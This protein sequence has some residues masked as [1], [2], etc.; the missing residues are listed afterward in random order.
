[1]GH[2]AEAALITML[3][4]AA[5]QETAAGTDDPGQL[6]SEMNRRL[7]RILPERVYVAA[8]AARVP[9][10]GC[11]VRVANA[12]LPFP[13]VLRASEHRVDELRQ[14]GLPLG[15]FDQRIQLGYVVRSVS[16]A[17]GDVLLIA[18]DGLGCIEGMNEQWFDDQRLRQVLRDLTGHDGR[19]IVDGL[20]AEAVAFSQG[21]PLPDDI[22]VVAVSRQGSGPCLEISPLPETIRQ[23]P[24]LISE[25]KFG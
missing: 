24:S 2:G 3:V 11:D 4:K 15:L 19:G 10:E 5:F 18:S 17:P 6:L 16:L 23:E 8:A 13:F 7:N 25:P 12:G 9:L 14:E 22:N 21:E 1:M 20:I